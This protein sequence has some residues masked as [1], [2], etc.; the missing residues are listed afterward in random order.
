MSSSSASF[1]ISTSFSAITICAKLSLTNSM[2][3]LGIV[4]DFEPLRNFQTQL[5]VHILSKPTCTLNELSIWNYFWCPNLNKCKA[6]SSHWYPLV[7]LTKIG[8][9]KT[10]FTYKNTFTSQID[11]GCSSSLVHTRPY[12][13][14]CN[15]YLYDC[16]HGQLNVHP[17]WTLKKCLHCWRTWRGTPQLSIT[18]RPKSLHQRRTS[19]DYMCQQ[20]WAN[21]IQYVV[22][23]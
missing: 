7:N 19:M 22:N 6:H 13:L 1:P 2:C 8:L 11:L 9:V 14:H 4:F 3:F 18:L 21:A 17:L 20:G 10:K 16:K 15:L 5:M 12:N 23:G